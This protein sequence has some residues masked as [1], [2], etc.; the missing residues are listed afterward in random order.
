MDPECRRPGKAPPAWG[1]NEIVSLVAHPEEEVPE[2]WEDLVGHLRET[3]WDPAAS[4]QAELNEALAEFSAP[5]PALSRKRVA[6]LT[7]DEN[8]RPDHARLP[9]G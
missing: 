1:L 6:V 3:G 8:I 7:E 5:E 4:H 9:R 2:H